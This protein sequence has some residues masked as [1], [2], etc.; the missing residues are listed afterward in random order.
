MKPNDGH[1]RHRHHRRH[2]RHRP[3]FLPRV[4]DGHRPRVDDGDDFL[5]SLQSFLPRTMAQK[6]GRWHKRVDD[7]KKGGR[8]HQLSDS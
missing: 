3:P 4:D 5:Q 2:R 8:W 1:R 7:G 6:G